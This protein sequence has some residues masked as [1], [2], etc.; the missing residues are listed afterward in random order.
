MH[1][2]PVES[3]NPQPSVTIAKQLVGLGLPHAS[4]KWIRNAH[5]P[6]SELPDGAYSRNQHSAVL[7]VGYI[8]DSVGL[9]GDGTEFRRSRLPPP[10]PS[11]QSAPEIPDAVFM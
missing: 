1:N 9:S 11:Q 4:G 7:A 5:F 10:P 3:S 8:W 6:A 2:A